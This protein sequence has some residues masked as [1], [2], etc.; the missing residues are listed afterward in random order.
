MNLKN[1]HRNCEVLS[2]QGSE[3]LSMGK[4]FVIFDTDS[5]SPMFQILVGFSGTLT[6]IVNSKHIN[7]QL[8][9]LKDDSKFHSMN[10]QSFKV[11]LSEEILENTRM[12]IQ[13]NCSITARDL[14]EASQGNNLESGSKEMPNSLEIIN[15]NG[16]NLNISKTSW[17]DSLE[18]KGLRN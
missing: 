2:G 18:L 16:K 7:L 10:S 14:P 5:V 17:I 12:K 13:S 6:G 9:E 8:S 4:F 3:S 11:G 15:E 1:V